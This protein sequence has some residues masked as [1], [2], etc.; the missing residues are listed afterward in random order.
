M[1]TDDVIVSFRGVRK[2]YDGETLVVKHLDLDIYQG[3]F[4]TLLGPSGSGKTT[5]LMM[6]AGFEFPTGGEIRLE[7]TLLN[8]V[9]PHKRN[10]GMV[11][12]NYAL[13]PH[14]TVAQNVEYPLTVRKLAA[15][16]R[17]ERVH[18]ALKMVRMEGFAKRYPA[19]LSG[20]QQQR[21]ALARALVFEPK[22]VLMDEPLGALDKQL[23]EHMQYELKS[24]H[25][26]LGVTF[27][28]VTHDQGEALTM[29]DRVAVFDKGVVQQLD[30]VDRLYES[31]CNAFVANF[32]GD[33]NT[34]R[35]TVVG[36]DGGYCELQLNDGAR[37]VGRN[38]A[39]APVGASAI[40]CIRPERMRLTEPAES[41]AGNALAGQTRGLVYFG[42]HVRMRCALPEQAECF[43]KVPLGTRALESFAPGAPIRLEF[44]PEHLRVF[45]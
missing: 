44:A 17:A 34:L 21:I 31:P 30:T 22:L 7:G 14:L 36:I 37:V 27:V 40:G 19:Q 42:D 33:S 41:G 23:R 26:K 1:K 12:Q 28:Y 8:T 9:P 45:T 38:I 16:E 5:C 35:G 43:V 4:L 20:G 29:S 24:L 6:L 25:E 10:I 13:F 11:F 2:T 32:I 39:G 3:E 18:H 15:A